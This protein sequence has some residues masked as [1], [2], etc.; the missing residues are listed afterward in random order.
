MDASEVATPARTVAVRRRRTSAGMTLVELLVSLAVAGVILGA[1]AVG[2]VGAVGGLDY[3]R[4][5]REATDLL[6][7]VIEGARSEDLAAVAVRSDAAGQAELAADPNLTTSGGVRWLD[8]DGTGPLGVE[9]VVTSSTGAITPRRQLVRD[10][11]PYTVRTYVTEPAD[12]AGSER[13]VVAVV[14]WQR[15]QSLHQRRAAT[16]IAATRRGLPLPRFTVDGASVVTVNQG[17]ILAVPLTIAN[18]GY[19]D[20][21]TLTAT[22]PGRSWHV[23]WYLDDDGNGL[24][25]AGEATLMG[26]TDGDGA[27]DSGLLDT[28]EVIK[29]VAVAALDPYDVP[30]DTALTLTATPVSQPDSGSSSI[31]HAVTVVSQSC[32]GCTY[33]PFFLADDEGLPVDGPIETQMELVETVG[34]PV[35]LPN[36]DTDRNLDPGRTLAAGGVPTGADPT[37]VAVWGRQMADATTLHGTALVRLYVA[38]K[39][40]NPAVIAQ[41][42]VDLGHVRENGT[43]WTVLGSATTVAVTFGSAFAVVDLA[44]S[45]NAVVP[46]NRFLQL[47]LTAPVATAPVWLGY[48]TAANP[49]VLQIPVDT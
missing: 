36:Y 49:S 27:V 15:S 4:E 33:A 28:D 23:D 37:A 46:R 21:W 11:T 9:E 2:L 18:R 31:V 38:A 14:S 32:A 42:R 22:A 6:T 19:R 26:D 43:S 44:V 20:R 3:A 25:D 39:D 45:V 16:V 47:R 29:L 48:G 10:G 30:G 8:P 1:G 12:A 17:A 24:H 13:R 35:V 5:N 40:F 41:L 34:P 7:E